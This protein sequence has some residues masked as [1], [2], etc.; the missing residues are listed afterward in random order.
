MLLPACLANMRGDWA[1]VASGV[2]SGV[3]EKE[4][5]ENVGD[6]GAVECGDAGL[7]RLRR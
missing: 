6:E 7:D 4:P 5:C 3:G 2:W 1:G